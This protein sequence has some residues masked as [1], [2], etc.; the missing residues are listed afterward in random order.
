MGLGSWEACNIIVMEAFFCNSANNLYFQSFINYT[1]CFP[2]G[3][4][5]IVVPP[6]KTTL[7]MSLNALLRCQAVAN[8]PNMTYVWQKS[9]ENV[10]HIE[11]VQS[12]LLILELSIVSLWCFMQCVRAGGVKCDVQELIFSLQC[13]RCTCI[14]Y[15]LH[16]I[17]PNTC[18]FHGRI[19][20]KCFRGEAVNRKK[21][22]TH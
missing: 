1:C 11:W 21:S 22:G 4:P 12:L 5:V 19:G 16:L 6:K 8:P 15:L 18:T 3:P 10:Y 20:T 14:L 7:N 13:S 17:K 9:G 2:L